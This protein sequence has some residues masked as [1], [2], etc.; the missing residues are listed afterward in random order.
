M[1]DLNHALTAEPTTGIGGVDSGNRIGAGGVVSTAGD[2]GTG[3]IHDDSKVVP[4]TAMPPRFAVDDSGRGALGI[5]AAAT[6]G[7]SLALGLDLSLVPESLGKTSITNGNE[8]NRNTAMANSG[9]S[10]TIPT[11]IAMS[12]GATVSVE[13]SNAGTNKASTMS[14][15]RSSMHSSHS[16]PIMSSDMSAN[17]LRMFQRMDEISARLIAMEEVFQKL[18]KSVDEQNATIKDLKHENAQMSKELSGQISALSMQQEQKNETGL[19]DT[20][21]TDLLNSITNVSSAYLRRMRPPNRNKI[22]Q[23]SVRPVSSM[24][25]VSTLNHNLNGV[26][27][28][29]SNGLHGDAS[30]FRNFN[31]RQ[32]GHATFTLNPNGIK[33]RKKNT[34]SGENLMSSG[35]NSSNV[36]SGMQS[37]KDLTSLNAFGTISLPNLTLDHTGMTPLLKGGNNPLSSTRLQDQ[38]HNPSQ[39]QPGGIPLQANHITDPLKGQ[40]TID[41][42]ENRRTQDEDDDGYQEDDDDDNDSDGSDDDEGDEGDEEDEDD[43]ADAGRTDARRQGA[44]TQPNYETATVLTDN[45]GHHWDSTAF[46]NKHLSS[47]NERVPAKD[48]ESDLSCR[49]NKPRK[50]DS[51]R[52]DASD[53]HD[54]D[55]TLLKAPS[56]VQTIWEEYTVGIGGNP[57]IKKLEEQFGN[58]WRLNRNR[59]TFAR[60]K[61]LYKFILNGISKGKTAEEMIKILE[62]RRLYKDENGE[63]KRRTIGWLQ[64]SLTGI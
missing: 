51:K 8:A 2:R 10:S 4:G 59:K 60:R 32:T 49:G 47:K 20:F 64:Q 24:N 45:K 26:E 54:E 37:Y 12:N 42:G 52:N 33:R 55:Y 63:V 41:D 61:R 44:S 40:P 29:E 11:P 31:D 57:P 19:Q 46:S 34:A 15:L 5:P 58:K 13:G 62:E 9:G 35:L 14:G 25:D 39:G 21:V 7:D 16:S 3:L 28:A 48:G 36:A 22:S 50:D 17:T 1:S 30:Q 56:N 6:P 23:S 38:L 53:V 43:V 18:C 27:F